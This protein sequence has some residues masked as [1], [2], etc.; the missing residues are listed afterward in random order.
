[1][2]KR[3]DMR[4]MKSTMEGLKKEKKVRRKKSR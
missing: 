3:G 1:M 4:A 2:Q